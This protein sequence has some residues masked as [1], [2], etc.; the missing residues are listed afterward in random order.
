LD[1]WYYS[2][3]GII[4]IIPALTTDYLSELTALTELSAPNESQRD[5]IFSNRENRSRF[6]KLAF[7]APEQKQTGLLAQSIPSWYNTPVLGSVRIKRL[8]GPPYS[9][10]ICHQIPDR[11]AGDGL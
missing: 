8:L 3:I 5:A 7:T 2:V 11:G 9:S 10:T 6:P 4:G 1:K